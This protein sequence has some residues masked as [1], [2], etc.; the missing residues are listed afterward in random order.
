M[1]TASKH[2]K[3]VL[4]VS[5]SN[6][7]RSQM[8]EGWMNYYGKGAIEV[9]SAGVVKGSLDW[10]AANAMMEAVID[11]TKY[12]SKSLAEVEQFIPDFVIIL[13]EEAEEYR[14][15][16]SEKTQ[17]FS[18]HFPSPPTDTQHREIFYRTLCNEIENFCF[19]FVDANI[20]KL[21]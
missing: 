14:A 12:T 2:L 10:E 16:V 21:I 19:D 6:S 11:I 8:A 9:K 18:H 1:Q 15:L 3:K 4:L 5:T 13:S 7:C 20:K 17:C